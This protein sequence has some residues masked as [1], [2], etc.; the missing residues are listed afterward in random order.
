[1]H[2]LLRFARDAGRG[3]QLQHR[4]PLAL[5]QT[6][7]QH[8]LPVGEFQG[9]VVRVRAVHVD[10]PESSHL[11]SK[12]PELHVWQQPAKGM[13]ALYLALECHFGAG[14]KAHCHIRFSD[15]AKPRV[16]KSNFVV[17]SLFPTFAG[18]DATL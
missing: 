7:D 17:T 12:F 16:R 10:P 2:L 5:A 4:R 14:K 9:V 1:V 13:L 11:I 6:G 3:R 8:D 15:A 18:R